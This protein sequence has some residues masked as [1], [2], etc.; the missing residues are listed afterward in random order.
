MREY[1]K[2]EVGT[3]ITRPINRIA[4]KVFR[5]NVKD[6]QKRSMSLLEF[7]DTETSSGPPTS[8]RLEQ[9]L[10]EASE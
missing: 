6:L 10:S 4:H 9:A 2:T 3:L 8:K 5:Q 7:L 1:P